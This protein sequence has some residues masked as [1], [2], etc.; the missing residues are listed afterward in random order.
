[1]FLNL[2]N[3]SVSLPTLGKVLGIF[4]GIA[5][6]FCVIIL[7]ITKVCK[8]E[9]DEKVLKILERLG[10]S[11]CGGCGCSGC[12]AFAKKLAD[13][14]GDIHDCHATTKQNAMEIAKILGVEIGDE[15]PTVA[16][17]ACA[18]G[19]NAKDNFNFVGYKDC[20]TLCNF[21]GG[22][23]VCP[24]ACLGGGDCE[25][26]CSHDAVKIEN[27]VSK[28]DKSRCGSC[29]ACIMACP[30]KIIKRV[31]RRAKV[32]VACSS[33]CKGK[34]VMGACQKG[35]IGCGL[36]AKNCPEGAITMENNLP[37]IDYK[38]CTGCKTCIAKCPRK[39]IIEL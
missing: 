29:G 28:I 24:S 18:G 34:D 10:G 22:D 21:Q 30:K 25:R 16:V 23:K 7:V 31:P 27:G 14:N 20:K 39:T 5:L 11:N 9:E 12:S 15:E 4:S 35:C 33:T 6:L 3:A 13:G 32:L 17:V 36:C 19:E 1:M 26:A 38:K 37:V 2:L 8:V